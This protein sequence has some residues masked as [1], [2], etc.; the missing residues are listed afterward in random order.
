MDS[1]SDFANFP[2]PLRKLVNNAVP[3]MAYVRRVSDGDTIVVYMDRRFYDGSLKRLR[4]KGINAAELNTAEGQ[5]AKETLEKLVKPETPLVV[6]T[7]KRTYDRFEAVVL[8]VKG[9]KVLNLGD[10]LVRLGV[11]KYAA[12]T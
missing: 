7:Y 10:E 1:L 2:S 3:A 5:K 6:T 12:T 8:F 9:G 4:L 11:A